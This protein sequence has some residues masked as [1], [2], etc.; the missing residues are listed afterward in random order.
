MTP[1]NVGHARLDNS[2]AF[3]HTNYT[4]KAY[5]YIC[6]Y[7]C[8]NKKATYPIHYMHNWNAKYCTYFSNTIFTKTENATDS[9]PGVTFLLAL[10]FKTTICVSASNF[11]ELELK[12]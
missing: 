9:S 8:V 4:F 10:Q 1:R 12:C 3:V 2:N 7:V 5:M 6:M 11:I